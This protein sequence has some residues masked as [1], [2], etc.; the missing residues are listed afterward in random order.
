M[1]TP[2]RQTLGLPKRICVTILSI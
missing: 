1:L 2:P